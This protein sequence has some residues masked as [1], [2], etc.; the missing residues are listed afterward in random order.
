MPACTHGCACMF[1]HVF[2]YFWTRVLYVSECLCFLNGWSLLTA[3]SPHT[4]HPLESYPNQ[5]RSKRTPIPRPLALTF[6]ECGGSIWKEIESGR[7][8]TSG[9]RRAGTGAKSG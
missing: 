1:T 3:T 6:L 7:G 2:L 9:K 4:S 8:E 5:I